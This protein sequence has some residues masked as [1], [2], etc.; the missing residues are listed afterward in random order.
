MGAYLKRRLAQEIANNGEKEKNMDIQSNLGIRRQ[1]NKADKEIMKALGT[2]DD[3]HAYPNSEK[4]DVDSYSDKD[5]NKLDDQLTNVMCDIAWTIRYFSRPYKYPTIYYSSVKGLKKIGHQKVTSIDYDSKNN[6]LILS[7]KK[8]PSKQSIKNKHKRMAKNY[9]KRALKKYPNK[10]KWL[11]KRLSDMRNRVNRVN[12][13]NRIKALFLCGRYVNTIFN[14][15]NHFTP[16]VFVY[17]IRPILS[18]FHIVQAKFLMW[19]AFE[20]STHPDKV[21]TQN[22]YVHLKELGLEA[23]DQKRLSHLV[24]LMH[25]SPERFCIIAH[26]DDEGKIKQVRIITPKIFNQ[27]VNIC[28]R[29]IKAL[30][31]KV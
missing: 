30:K 10:Y 28:L 15:G 24:Y 26:T 18:K 27:F 25:R 14:Y 20:K 8:Y 4:L 17:P 22:L 21:N 23:K 12:L 31:R 5:L 19:V 1:L 9:L 29:R 11:L 16:S 7:L 3:K 6:K 13:K 2:L